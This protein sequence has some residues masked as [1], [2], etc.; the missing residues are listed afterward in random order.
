MTSSLEDIR[1]MVAGVVAR[2]ENDTE[3]AQRLRADPLATLAAAGIPAVDA[4]TIRDGF[5][6]AAGEVEGFG[7]RPMPWCHD[8]YKDWDPT[9]IA[10]C[11]G[12]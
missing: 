8:T 6:A 1:A 5:A 10:V 2:A 11:R 9:G 3:F 4:E 7:V 12:N